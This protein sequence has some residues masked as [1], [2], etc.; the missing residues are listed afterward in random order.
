MTIINFEVLQKILNK[1]NLVL[2][3]HYYSEEN[4]RDFPSNFPYKISVTNKNS[5]NKK[6]KY[7]F[8]QDLETEN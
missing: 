5:Y 6:W 3:A 4:D 7:K 1:F 2:V 8:E